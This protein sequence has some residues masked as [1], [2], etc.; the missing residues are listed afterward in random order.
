MLILDKKIGTNYQVHL[1]MKAISL[2]IF[3]FLKV[4][5]FISGCVLYTTISRK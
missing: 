4:T 3:Y 2:V 5:G 1:I